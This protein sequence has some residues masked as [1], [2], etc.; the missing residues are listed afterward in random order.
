MFIILKAV[1][2]CAYGNGFNCINENA[3]NEIKLMLDENDILTKQ[4]KN[5]QTKNKMNDNQW[6]MQKHFIDAHICR[7]NFNEVQ[8]VG[9]F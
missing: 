6:G 8:K 5:M 4:K 7:T 1:T 9:E 2:P 3:K